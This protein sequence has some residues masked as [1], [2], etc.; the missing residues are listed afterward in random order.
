MN[1]KLHHPQP[2]NQVR[3]S[4]LL[5]PEDPNRVEVAYFRKLK[6]KDTREWFANAEEYRAY[7]EYQAHL[8]SLASLN[9]FPELRPS[10]LS[11]PLR[12][13]AWILHGARLDP[14]RDRERRQ[15]HQLENL[16]FEVLQDD[17]ADNPLIAAFYPHIGL[18]APP[19]RVP[20]IVQVDHRDRGPLCLPLAVVTAPGEA[21]LRIRAARRLLP[22]PEPAVVPSAIDSLDDDDDDDY[23]DG[24]HDDDDDDDEDDDYGNRAVV[25]R[26]C[27][28]PGSAARS[29]IYTPADDLFK[30]P[31]PAA[32]QH[33]EPVEPVACRRQ[34]PR[35]TGQAAVEAAFRAAA[36]QSGQQ[37]LRQLAP[38]PSV[39]TTTSSHEGAA[40]IVNPPQKK[41]Q[42][43]LIP[44][45]FMME[46]QLKVP[47]WKE[48]LGDVP[49]AMEPKGEEPLVAGPQLKEPKGKEPEEKIEDVIYVKTEPVDVEMSDYDDYDAASSVSSSKAAAALPKSS[50]PVKTGRVAKNSSKSRAASPKMT[51]KQHRKSPSPQRPSAAVQ[52]CVI[53]H[54]PAWY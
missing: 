24:Y 17:G 49:Q 23:H 43:Q 15:R 54:S 9:L 39:A 18:R 12:T 3:W 51:A 34:P 16:L 45:P 41:R 6:G 4:Q 7:C 38:R 48:S 20:R 26:H 36:V 47:K 32:A 50:K 27:G 22:R 33:I 5:S 11:G 25:S 35:T 21:E 28:I 10:G 1:P 52:Q 42:P 40:P 14:R 29:R 37:V 13:R 30:L 2:Q 53:T 8:P 19:P 46:F 31:L 44:K